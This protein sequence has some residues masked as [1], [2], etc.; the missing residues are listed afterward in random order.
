MEPILVPKPWGGR[1]LSAL[2]KDLPPDGDFGESWEIADLPADAV[3]SSGLSRTVVAE[4]PFRGAT[5]RSLIAERGA[6]LLGSA[7]PTADGDFP[8]LVKYLDAREDLSVQV[9]P[10]EAFVAQHRIG[11]VKTESWYV[12]AAEPDAVLY[13]G[14]REG[15]E[16]GD[17]VERVGTPALVE[18]LDAVPAV[19][20]EFHHLPA[21][22]VHALGAGVV[23]AEPQTPSDTT[24]RLYDWPDQHARA[25]RPLHIDDGLAAL[26]IAAT[27]VSLPALHGDGH[28]V[29]IET[30]RYW[31]A[32]HRSSFGT[33]HIDDRPELRVLMVI[34]GQV[35]LSIGGREPRRGRG[36]DTVIIPAAGAAALEVDVAAPATVLELALL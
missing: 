18:L 20:G 5:L 30:D 17:V 19:P 2:G 25:A 14:F 23:V 3:T 11:H 16:S 34:S 13:L 33:I 28:R 22:L 1:R 35:I 32:E 26:R 6:E 4:G 27:P 7:P 9:H 24:F 31:A 36:G 15:V 21:G 10:D 29:L 12:V 8:L